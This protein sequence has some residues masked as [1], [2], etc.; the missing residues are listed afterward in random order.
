MGRESYNWAR[1]RM[2][3]FFDA[4]SF[5]FI[6]LLMWKGHQISGRTVGGLNITEEGEKVVETS[7][8]TEP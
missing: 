5:L 8:S 6:V 7:R 4:F 1:I 2:I 3:A